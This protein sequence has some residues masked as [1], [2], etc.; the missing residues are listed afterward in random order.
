[1]VILFVLVLKHIL[2]IFLLQLAAQR[3]LSCLF[4]FPLQ[5][6]VSASVD[7]SLCN[8]SEL[9]PNVL[10][11]SDRLG[12]ISSRPK[13]SELKVGECS[14]FFTYVKSSVPTNNHPRFG[15]VDENVAPSKQLITKE[16]LPLSR[17]QVGDTEGRNS[18]E[19]WEN[20]SHGSSFLGGENIPT[21][22]TLERSS[23]APVPLYYP[24]GWNLSQEKFSTSRLHPSNESQVEVPH[25][26]SLT[27]LPFYLPGMMNQVMMPS[28]GQLY[29]GSLHEAPKCT[30]PAMLPQYNALPQCPHVPMM[31]PFSYYPV[32]ANLQPG[33]MHR[34]YLWPSIASSSS[35]EV[36]SVR[37][38]RR[39]A[40]L[41][42]FRQKRKDR[43]FDK[44][45]RYVNPK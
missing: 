45:I 38:E 24:Q 29:Q 23:S 42:K 21:F 20:Y 35:A 22:S 32:N 7:P 30:T 28:S 13:K 6:N 19:E 3:C 26:P 37:V 43:C 18:R 34:P 5:S 15:C 44:K 25:I 9:Y 4:V 40:A 39:E 2:C 16:K 11:P 36:K 33:Q 27:P 14:A 8:L 17:T 41:M 1:M 10:V 12:G 31:T